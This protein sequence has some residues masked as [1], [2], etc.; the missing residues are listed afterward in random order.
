MEKLE[1][2]S[3]QLE[4]TFNQLK[5]TI[6][7]LNDV[8]LFVNQLTN[9]SNEFIHELKNITENENFKKLT[10]N[11]NKLAVDI[12]NKITIINSHLQEIEVYRTLFQ[13]NIVEYNTKIEKFNRSFEEKAKIASNAEQNLNRMINRLKEWDRKNN[14]S[15]SDLIKLAEEIHLTQRY[16]EVKKEQN[17]MNRKL[18]KIIGLLNNQSK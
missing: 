9:S 16:E 1:L 3:N 5:D 4:D 12:R 18:D 13:D 2:I 10:N 6:E 14:K 7:K 17:I 11:N 15:R 8:K